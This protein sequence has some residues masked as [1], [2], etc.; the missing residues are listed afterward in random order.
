MDFNKE[1]FVL[2]FIMAISEI[3]AQ[4]LIKKGA[5]HPDDFNIFVIL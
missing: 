3:S 4:F 5:D 1:L 2:F